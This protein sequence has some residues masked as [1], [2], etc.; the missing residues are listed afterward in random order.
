VSRIQHSVAVHQSPTLLQLP[1]KNLIHDNGSRFP[2]AGSE[3]WV[4]LREFRA[5]TRLPALRQ[6]LTFLSSMHRGW[7]IPIP[8]IEMLVREHAL[9]NLSLRECD[10]L[11]FLLAH[12][13]P[14]LD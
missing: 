1:R 2:D 5:Q 9:P 3:T 12:E 10:S 6:R 4:D 14:C 11:W 13:V 7:G 8:E